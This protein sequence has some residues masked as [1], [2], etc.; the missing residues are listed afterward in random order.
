MKLTI[1]NIAIYFLLKYFVLSII[2]VLLNVGSSFFDNNILDVLGYLLLVFVAPLGVPIAII[3]T[4]PMY[5]IK[6]VKKMK[7][8]LLLL[9][10]VFILEIS[11]YYKLASQ[12]SYDRLLLNF[13]IGII[14]WILFFLKQFLKERKVIS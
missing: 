10:G 3:L 8:A 12:H 6:K 1:F 2:T 7:F 9:F 11:I 13:L 4:Y 5:L 14:F